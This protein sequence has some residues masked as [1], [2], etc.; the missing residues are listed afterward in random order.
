MDLSVNALNRYSIAEL[1]TAIELFNDAIIRTEVDSAAAVSE[2]GYMQNRAHLALL[3]ERRKY[4][5]NLLSR[6][7]G[8][9]QMAELKEAVQEKV[10]RNLSNPVRPFRP[11]ILC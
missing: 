9:E 10:Q 6:L 8:Q 7:S 11:R 5:T 3:R 4:A 2:D 1:R